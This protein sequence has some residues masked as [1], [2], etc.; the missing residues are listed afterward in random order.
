MFTCGH[1]RGGRLGL[2]HEEPNLVGLNKKIF[3]IANIIVNINNVIISYYVGLVQRTSYT[4]DAWHMMQFLC[5]DVMSL[6][7]LAGVCTTIHFDVP[8][9]CSLHYPLQ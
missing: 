4:V 2:G 5:Y 3:I 6:L 9:Y 8:C 7:D 1:G